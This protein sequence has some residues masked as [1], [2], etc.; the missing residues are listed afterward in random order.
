MRHAQRD[1]ERYH[2]RRTKRVEQAATDRRPDGEHED[3][4]DRHGEEEPEHR[5]LQKRIDLGLDFRALVGHDHDTHVRRKSGEAVDGVANGG[6]Y[7]DGVRLGGL[8]DRH[9]HAGLAV[10]AGDAGRG[11]RSETH[12]RDVAQADGTG[13]RRADDQLLYLLDGIERVRRLGDDGLAAVEYQARGQRQVVLAES[14]G[15][16][17]QRQPV[18]RQ[19]VRVDRN[20]DATLYLSG[21]LDLHDAVDVG[22]SRQ[23]ARPDDVLG[24]GDVPVRYHAELYD[25]YLGRIES[26]H[27]RFFRACR[28]DDVVHG[29]VDVALGGRHIGPELE[30]REHQGIA[31]GRS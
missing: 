12:V 19:F 21:G 9:A 5:L 29:G 22:D 16:L 7:L 1:R 13:C 27:R 20:L 3:E 8:Q 26:A 15:Y 4:H 17:Q 6:R 24:V 30:G 11:A 18:R 14:G 25:R 23:D 2:D 10:G 31:L 28:E